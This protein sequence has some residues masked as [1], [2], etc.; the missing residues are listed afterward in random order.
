MEANKEF[1]FI[2]FKREY[3]CENCEA[4]RNEMLEL[5]KNLIILTKIDNGIL[6][7]DVEKIKSQQNEILTVRQKVFI[8]HIYDSLVSVR[9][10]V[11][12]KRLETCVQ[13]EINSDTC[14]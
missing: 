8:N 7:K 1:Q 10:F 3:K 4:L 13:F 9:R 14:V 12:S 11:Q 6:Q 2:E 5:K